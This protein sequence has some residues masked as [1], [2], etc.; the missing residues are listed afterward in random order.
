[1]TQLFD[2][3]YLLECYV[4][5][6]KRKVGYFSLPILYG[7]NFVGQVDIK[8]DRKTKILWIKNLVWEDTLKNP[9]AI[10][11]PFL[12][13]LTAF[14][15]FNGCEKIKSESPTFAPIAKDVSP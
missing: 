6:K 5:A 12:K 8:A 7:K 4:T 9:A 1:M 14:M 15:V 2:F 10:Y 13:K 11:T 3:S